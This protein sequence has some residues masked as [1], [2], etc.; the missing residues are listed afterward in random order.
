MTHSLTPARAAVAYRGPFAHA[1]GRARL[2]WCA[3]RRI[4]ITDYYDLGE[5]LVAD[6]YDLGEFPIIDYYDL[7]EFQV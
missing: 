6:D 7:G 4:S 1:A 5:F 2:A 3:S